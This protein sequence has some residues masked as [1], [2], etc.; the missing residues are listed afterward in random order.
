MARGLVRAGGAVMPETVS[1]GNAPK[2]SAWLVLPAYGMYASLFLFCIAGVLHF[3]RINQTRTGGAYAIL[4]KFPFNL[5]F[6][7]KYL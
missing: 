2:P 4:K 6:I 1:D 7:I 3:E 5:R